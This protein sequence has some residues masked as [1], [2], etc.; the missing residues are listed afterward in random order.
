MREREREKEKYRALRD[1]PFSGKKRQFTSIK[2]PRQCPL[3]LVVK[4]DSRQG[5]AFG[6][7]EGKKIIC[8]RVFLVEIHFEFCYYP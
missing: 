5:Q 7:G 3:V 1:T 4:I 8:G 6:N 2:V